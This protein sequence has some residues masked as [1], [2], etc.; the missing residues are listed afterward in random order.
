MLTGEAPPIPSSDEKL[1]EKPEPSIHELHLL[2]EEMEDERSRSRWREAIWISVVLHLLLIISFLLAPKIFPQR[3]NIVLL[4]PTDRMKD[5]DM[6]FLDLPPDLQKHVPPPKTDVLSDKNRIAT[7]RQPVLDRKALEKILNAQKPGKPGPN[8]TTPKPAPQA[9]AQ[10]ASAPPAQQ[11]QQQ[12]PEQKTDPNSIAKLQPPPVQKAAPGTFRSA[13]SAGSAIQQAAQAAA[14]SRGTG[15]GGDFGIGPIRPN[16]NV[17]GSMDVLS[18]TMGVDFGPYLQRVLHDV[19][20]NWY[21]LIPEVAR[22][23]LMKKGRVTIEFAI[24]KD[25]SVMGM[26]PV[27]GSGDVSL[28]RAAWG[29]ITA[30]NPFPPLPSEFGGEYLALRFRFYYNPDK[31]DLR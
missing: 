19:K 29:G 4:S 7:A 28:D 5:R 21:N 14:A 24:M 1:Q 13:M 23:P 9:P 12:A 3:D 2:L 27:S 22:P 16:S 8:G 15:G 20:F 11:P 31:N 30:S 10:V 18:D 25:G 26:R 6:T 17:Q